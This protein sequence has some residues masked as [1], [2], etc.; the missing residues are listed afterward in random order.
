MAE[1][2]T[3]GSWLRQR[4]RMLDLSAEE[5]AGRA[6]CP[7]AEIAALEGD[8]RPPTRQTADA[9]A[10]VLGVAPSDRPLFFRIAR[11]DLPAGRLSALRLSSAPAHPEP[12][13][14]PS[15]APAGGAPPAAP[16]AAAAGHASLPASPL[17]MWAPATPAAGLSAGRAGL[18]LPAAPLVDRRAEL[19]LL[20]ERLAD[21]GCRM[22]T[23]VG[24]PGIGKTRL[25]LHAAGQA[26]AGFAQ[27]AA[28]APLAPV[29]APAHIAHAIAAAAG[30]TLYG[31]APAL[32]Q[33]IA[34][35]GP[36]RML[37][38]LDD[39]EHLLDGAA[40]E[41]GEAAA[42]GDSASAAAIFLDLLA[43]AAEVKLLVTS[44]ERLGAAGEWVVELGGLPLAGPEG[45][46]AGDE[47][48][49][50]EALFTASARRSNHLFQPDA[51][52]R[53]A[54]SRLCRMLDGN[55]LGIE[56]AAAWSRLLSPGEIEAE[57][58][59]SLDLLTATARDLPPRHR[60]LRAA[61]D[62]SWA[63]LCPAEQSA[64]ARLTVFRGPFT[65]Q[66]AAEVAGADLALLAALVDKS[67]LKRVE[68]GRFDL[69]EP[70]RQAAA[71]KL[72]ASG[73]KA[74]AAGAHLAWYLALAERTA[75]RLTGPDQAAA[76]DELALE[77]NNL[78]VAYDWCETPHAEPGCGVRLGAALW[79]FWSV[80]GHGAE[81]RARLAAALA[82]PGAENVPERAAAANGAGLLAWRQG[83]I[84]AA[85]RLGE[86]AAALCRAAG[87]GR[88]LGHALVLLSVVLDAAGEPAA[89]RAAGEE[90][91][92][93]FRTTPDRIGLALA[94]NSLGEVARAHG[95]LDG[96]SAY[97]GESLALFRA[98]GHLRG[99]ADLLHNLGYVAF[100]RGE[101]QQAAALFRESLAL[102]RVQSNERGMAETL[103]G[104]ASLLVE[105]RPA[106]AVRLFSAAERLLAQAGA[107]LEP[108]DSIE[109]ERS[110]A[111]ALARL[112][113]EEQ[114]ACRA[115]GA[116]LSLA[117]ALRL[118]EETPL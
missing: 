29:A 39:V 4:R 93:L 5:L 60:S 72:A 88:G 46:P 115:S 33:L 32:E 6:G 40:A 113:A 79:R 63:L 27:G 85:R 71:E 21:P 30:C 62:H 37:L 28:F 111:V 59:A 109:M 1:A 25:A 108:V 73:D 44:R 52:G 22:V 99:L 98:A 117:E 116:A 36:R 91:V 90:A 12:S 89:A 114:A 92:A 57:L 118:A 64:L 78:R 31:E 23:L 13:A 56:L 10:G 101:R 82:R 41:Q 7:P 42:A 97:Y 17:G 11:G 3:F 103:T 43:G 96:A 102:E 66:A 74:A 53:A 110:M 54:I 61:F 15:A 20:A 95:D 55:P 50:A 77:L 105:S 100:H 86:E 34:W 24:P 38:V 48:A 69:H 8:E 94:L 70:V 16:S 47:A 35:L 84:A 9:L 18:P 76:L 83:D 80:R 58:A 51:E 45:S 2:P 106:V 67:L 81:G 49:S 14:A 19:A 104:I 26:A 68:R 112:P 75:P 107:K 87:D 65:R